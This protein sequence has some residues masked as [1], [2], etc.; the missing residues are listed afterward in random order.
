MQRL[1]AL[2]FLGAA[3]A[4]FNCPDDGFYRDP[5]QCDKYYDC[6]RGEV[7]EKMCPDGLVFDDT[8]PPKVEQCNYPFIVQC[9]DGALLQPA[10]PSGIECPRQNG[11][12]E[13]EDPSNC[14]EYYECTTGLPVL[15]ECAR[16]LVFDEF[17]GTCQWQSAG[18][19]SGCVD[20]VHVLADGFSCP[21]ST[22]IHTNGQELDHKRYVNPNDCR[23][24]Y[25]CQDGKDPR[26]VGC[27]QGTVF[28]GEKLI[29]DAPE[30]VLECA[31]YYPADFN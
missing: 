18:F 23:F 26:E 5:N 27:P 9:P 17:T 16:G 15:R 29:C 22:Q 13:H 6:Y 4:Q 7:K 11:Y 24:F 8:Q 2:L 12:F 1:L 3:S 20:R 31:N 30:N 25:V 14:R 19:R 21:N 10:L 28:N